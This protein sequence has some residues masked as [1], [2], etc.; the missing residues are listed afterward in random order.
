MDAIISS[1]RTTKTMMNMSIYGVD[2]VGSVSRILQRKAGYSDSCFLVF[3]F[4][5]L[6]SLLVG[7]VIKPRT[8]REEWWYEWERQIVC[9]VKVRPFF[10]GRPTGSQ[11]RTRTVS[12]WR[13]PPRLYTGTTLMLMSMCMLTLPS[14]HKYKIYISIHILNLSI[15]LFSGNFVDISNDRS[16]D[17]KRNHQQ[18]YIDW[19]RVHFECGM[20]EFI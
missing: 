5:R 8:M 12:T 19:N 17:D 18:Y 16:T 7:T 15:N 6:I 13:G 1:G 20:C 9:L 2:C 10:L 4:F 14:F 3:L 11:S